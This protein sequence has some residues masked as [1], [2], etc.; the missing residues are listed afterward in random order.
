[1]R[2]LTLKAFRHRRIKILKWKSNHKFIIQYITLSFYSSASLS[3]VDLE[4]ERLQQKA[5]S[6]TLGQAFALYALRIFLNLVVLA[7]IGGTFYGIAEVTQFSQVQNTEKK[8]I[9]YCKWLLVPN[10][11]F[12]LLLKSLSFSVRENNRLQCVAV[13]V[14]TLHCH[15]NKQFCGAAPVWQ[16][17]FTGKAFSQYHRYSGLAAVRSTLACPQNKDITHKGNKEPEDEELIPLLFIIV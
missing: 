10:T 1:M 17:C 13:A 2:W 5:A 7:L 11:D 9:K 14:L 15:N 8:R 12:F 16:D 3:Q 4:E 6:L